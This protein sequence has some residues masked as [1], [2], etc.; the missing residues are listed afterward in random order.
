MKGLRRVPMPVIS[1]S[2]V[3]PGLRSGEVPSVPI[4]IISPGTRVMYLVIALI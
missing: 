4:Q 3:S 2:T 1:A